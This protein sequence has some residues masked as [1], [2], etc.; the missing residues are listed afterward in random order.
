[1]PTNVV[2]AGVGGQGVLLS[3]RVLVQAAQYEGHDVKG[4]EVHGMAQRGGS[5][6][7]HVRFGPDVAS[8]IIRAGSA[9]YLVCLELLEAARKLPCLAAGGTLLC[10]DLRIDPAPVAGGSAAY[11]ENVS[12]WLRDTVARAMLLDARTALREGGIP[13]RSVNLFM[14]GALGAHL[15]FAES[16]WERAMRD[17]VKPR[18]IEPNLQAF[19]LGRDA[20]VKEAARH[21]HSGG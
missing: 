12:A 5:V 3:C 6:D 4:S 7:C 17:L 1:M 10:A 15:G 9:A 18:Y 14:L 20:A 11:P 2:V 21:A 19:A 13:P 16:S 8:P